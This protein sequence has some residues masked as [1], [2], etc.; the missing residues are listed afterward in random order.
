VCV[1]AKWYSSRK[2]WPL[3]Q[4]KLSPD[5]PNSKEYWIERTN[6]LFQCRAV[7]LTSS[8]DYSLAISQNGICP[9]CQQSLLEGGR[10][11]RHHILPTSK[12]GK[13]TLGNIVLI[14]AHC[15]SHIHY[16]GEFDAW[17]ETLSNY[18]Y[19]LS[20][21]KET[22]NWEPSILDTYEDV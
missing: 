1:H 13:N 18:K 4:N 10:L 8:F 17:F 11:Q 15:H 9:V 14:H 20:S 3:V 16:G 21:K 7:D 19:Q 22:F 6:K 5:D 2:I 12:G